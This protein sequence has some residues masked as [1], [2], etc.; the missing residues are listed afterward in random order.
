MKAFAEAGGVIYAECGGLLYLSQSL[1]PLG[2]LPCAMGASPVI[3][4]ATA[5]LKMPHGICTAAAAPA[6][7][8]HLKPGPAA[9]GSCSAPQLQSIDF[10]Q[11][12]LRLS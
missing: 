8:L 2:E 3:V 5:S 1:Q 12:V 11:L 7:G 6:A 10:D 4:I 9:S